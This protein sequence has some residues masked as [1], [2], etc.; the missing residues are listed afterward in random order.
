MVLD[1]QVVASVATLLVNLIVQ[2]LRLVIIA[3]VVL[4]DQ[5]VRFV[6][7]VAQLLSKQGLLFRSQ[8][9]VQAVI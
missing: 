7:G 4:L 6:A 8:L 5:V 9:I 1:N 3:V 2:N